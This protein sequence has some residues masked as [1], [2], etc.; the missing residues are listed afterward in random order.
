MKQQ[1][2]V[3]KFE[4]AFSVFVGGLLLCASFKYVFGTHEVYTSTPIIEECIKF[5]MSSINLG[6]G[7]VLGVFEFFAF[8]FSGTSWKIRLG[9]LLFHS[10]TAIVYYKNRNPKDMIPF[11]ILHVINN[12]PCGIV[13][14]VDFSL[15]TYVW[16]SMHESVLTNCF[17]VWEVMQISICSYLLWK[18]VIRKPQEN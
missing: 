4:M 8:V 2:K 5:L 14:A 16:I 9:G 17:Y 6:Y 12:F 10:I 18:K 15:S 3:T 1:R 7:L 13:R 11:I